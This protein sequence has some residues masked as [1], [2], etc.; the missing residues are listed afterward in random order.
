MISVFLVL[1]KQGP[2]YYHASYIVKIVT[3]QRSCN[4]HQT[5]ERIA[6]VTKKTMLYLEVY[7]PE[8]IDSTK[9]LDN[10]DKFN[11]K[12]VVIQRYDV[13]ERFMS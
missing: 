13:K 5:N 2:Q 3:S 4:E 10:L 9:Y 8:D 12:E 6:E 1:Y 7:H 11:V